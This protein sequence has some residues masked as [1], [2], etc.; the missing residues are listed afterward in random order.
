MT[1]PTRRPLLPSK[2]CLA[3]LLAAL[4]VAPAAHA[5]LGIDLSA[6]PKEERK[7]AKKK[8]AAKKPPV[9]KPA[10]KKPAPA[11]PPEPESP[12]EAPPPVP[13]PEPEKPVEALPGEPPEQPAAQPQ[14]LPGLKLAPVDPKAT[15][16]AKERLAAAKK[17]LDEK[18]TETAALAFD[19]ILREP[20]FAGVHDE[21]RYQR[22]K[23]LVRMGL[24][25]SALA[26]FDE[27]LEKGPR[28]SRF[29]HSAME[30]VFHVGRK[31]KNEQ[32]VL[33]RV[34]RHAQWGFPPAYED[35][36]H[37]LLAKYEFERGRALADAGR[38]AD[39]KSAWAEARRLA[40]MVRREAGAKPP[41][42][43]DAPSA[44]D[45]AGDVYAKA[46][47]VDGLVLFAQGDD[48]AS[49]EAFKE[50]VRL[51]NPKRGRHPDPELREL[52]FLQLARIHYQNRQNRYAIWY[53]GK[54]PWGGERW[55]EGLW[56]A[57][58]AHYRIADYE[59]TLGNLL[60][61]QS[62]YFQDEY[63]PESYVLEAIVYYENCRYPEARRVLESF[64][65]LYEP[66]YEELA[67]ITTRPQTPEAYFEVIEQSPRQKGGAIMRR[68]LKVAYTDQ[69]IRRLAES[70][71]EIEDEM[72]RG[73]GGRRPEFRES[74]LAKELLDKLGA[75]KATLVQEAGARARG[76]LEY[77]RDSL[78]TLLAQSLRIR[79]EVS[80]KER[81]ALEGAL[82]RGSQVEVV[83]D[84][85]YSTAVSDEHLY[86]PYQGEFWRDE[87]G[88]YSYTLTKGCKDRLPRSRAAA[89]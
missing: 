55:L 64:S 27:V 58:Y 76:K 36:F 63:F 23:A 31:L 41:V 39:A 40:S 75:D 88:T 57:S 51:T 11:K 1:R 15:A 12:R 74:A 19:Q 73:I 81:E 20:T 13:A 65:R 78:R 34:A 38:T 6:P 17:L 60:T 42:S 67:G 47:F 5:Q 3:V 83:R 25:H 87:L 46:R 29:Y 72:D 48:Q 85:K 86:W 53:Y 50:V 69:N 2:G 35:R 44:G 52:A 70:I 59:K 37:F 71:R 22:A 16:I 8:P 56:E 89:R 49:V 32:P 54:M 9:K 66:V 26:A 18:A 80:R 30:W 7:P 24:H 61:L 79:I 4:A 62:P 33:N 28:G 84:L 21:A 43:P 77:E 14:E 45:D 82:A 68:I 10:A